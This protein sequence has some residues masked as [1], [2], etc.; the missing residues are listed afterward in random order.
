MKEITTTYQQIKL[1]K[2]AKKI[3]T[4]SKTVQLLNFTH[5]A[6]NAGIGLAK[7]ELRLELKPKVFNVV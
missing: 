3:A 7:F 2:S 1:W 6:N 5:Q 4:C